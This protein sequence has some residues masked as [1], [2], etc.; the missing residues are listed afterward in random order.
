LNLRQPVEQFFVASLARRVANRL[1]GVDKRESRIRVLPLAGGEAREVVVKGRIG[2]WD[3]WT[4]Q[5]TERA[6]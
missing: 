6:F 1:Y 5:L 4:G 3:R 2:G